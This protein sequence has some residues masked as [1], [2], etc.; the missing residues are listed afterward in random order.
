M[1]MLSMNLFHSLGCR[2]Y[3]Y[4]YFPS[5]LVINKLAYKGANFVPIAV[6]DN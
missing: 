5:N 4:T 1:K 6:P 3:V 2:G